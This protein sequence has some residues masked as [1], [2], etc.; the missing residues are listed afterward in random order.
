MTPLS[1]ET[2]TILDVTRLEQDAR[3]MRA[4]YIQAGIRKGW[5]RI[6]AVFRDAASPAD[7]GATKA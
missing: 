3:R 1:N 4:A 5:N 6:T 2:L 7:H